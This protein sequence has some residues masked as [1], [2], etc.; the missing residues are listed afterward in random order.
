[1]KDDRFTWRDCAWDN[2]YEPTDPIETAPDRIA[3]GERL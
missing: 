2:G 3:S 1:V